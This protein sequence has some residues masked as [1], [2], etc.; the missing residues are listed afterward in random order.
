VYNYELGRTDRIREQAVHVGNLE[1]TFSYKIPV[2]GD[3]LYRNLT[4]LVDPRYVGLWE[5]VRPQQEAV[6]DLRARDGEEPNCAVWDC[7]PILG[8]QSIV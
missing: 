6:H 8:G 3:T 1:A 4:G 5:R 7:E 2:D